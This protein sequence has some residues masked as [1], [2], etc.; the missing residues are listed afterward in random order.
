MAMVGKGEYLT[1]GMLGEDG[2]K[3]FTLSMEKEGSYADW[4]V[5]EEE[6]KMKIPEGFGS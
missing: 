2:D 4:V 1:T 3:I 5:R 6:R